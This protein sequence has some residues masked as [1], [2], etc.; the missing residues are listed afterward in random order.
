MTHPQHIS[1]PR[2]TATE[3]HFELPSFLAG[4]TKAWGIFEDRFGRLRRRFDVEMH[5][6]WQ[7]DVFKLDERFVYDDGRV[8]QRIW[9]VKHIA[10]GRFEGTCDDC[11]G[12]A[13][14]TYSEG[15]VH[16]TY[17]FRLRLPSRT[18]SVD[19]DD[20]LYRINALTAI[21]RSTVRKWGIRIGE[22]S[23]FFQRQPASNSVERPDQPIREAAE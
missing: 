14:G 5:G 23:L 16:M 3:P 20:R 10:P 9:L 13:A 21:N 2:P 6:S 18:I 19:I 7:G 4:T 15:K 22:I 8:E 17:A 12:V 1:S 11:I